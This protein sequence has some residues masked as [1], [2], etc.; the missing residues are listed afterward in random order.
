MI[1]KELYRIFSRKITL[2]A[3]VVATAFLVYYGTFRIA[4]ET[5]IDD[6][7]VY[8]YGEAVTRDKRIAEE[9]AGPLTIETVQAIWEKYGVSANPENAVR[10]EELL[11]LAK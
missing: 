11:E 7:A 4:E 9:F 6:G 5:V 1:R 10:K 3:L 2:L 8:Q